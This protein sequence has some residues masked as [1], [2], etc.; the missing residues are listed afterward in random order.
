MGGNSL[1]VSMSY[2]D[3][4]DSAIEEAIAEVEA[5]MDARHRKRRGE[6]VNYVSKVIERGDHVVMSSEIIRASRVVKKMLEQ[7]DDGNVI[8]LD[9]SQHITKSALGQVWRALVLADEILD[10]GHEVL[11]IPNNSDM[12]IT[13]FD[14]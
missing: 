8:T 6:M 9:Y 5:E 3:F 2:S 1:S 10:T 12:V 7:L 13:S 14:F 4:T 11:D